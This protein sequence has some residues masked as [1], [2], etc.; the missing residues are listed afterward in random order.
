MTKRDIR[1][2]KTCLYGQKVNVTVEVGDVTEHRDIESYFYYHTVK[3]GYICSLGHNQ[4]INS[5]L[6]RIDY[7]DESDIE[8]PEC[9]L[10]FPRKGLIYTSAVID[11]LKDL[12][13]QIDSQPENADG[14]YNGILDG[15]MT[16][17][18]EELELRIHNW[19]RMEEENG[20]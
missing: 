17:V 2:C 19:N 6:D 8:Y 16:D 4:N 13:A 20:E 3:E 9:T 7:C 15:I 18:I 1:D 11:L 12:Y 14:R 10:Y 5:K